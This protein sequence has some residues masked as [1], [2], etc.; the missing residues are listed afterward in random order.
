MASKRKRSVAP[1]VALL[2]ALVIF[3]PAVRDLVLDLLTP[4]LDLIEDANPFRA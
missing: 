2:V 3:V 4:L 1:Y